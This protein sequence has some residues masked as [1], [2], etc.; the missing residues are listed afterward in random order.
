MKSGGLLLSTLALFLASGTTVH[1][2]HPVAPL[3]DDQ[4]VNL[5]W[6]EHHDWDPATVGI[7]SGRVYRRLRITRPDS[8]G[9]FP[10]C[11]DDVPP[12]NWET[13]D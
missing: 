9:Y 2:D 12:C 8:D 13:A 3:P 10:N 11:Q 6:R 4:F 7:E 1:A 5:A